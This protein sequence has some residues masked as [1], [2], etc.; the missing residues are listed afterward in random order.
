M[1][2]LVR[3]PNPTLDDL[4]SYF[5]PEEWAT[6]LRDITCSRR[7]GAYFADA[8]FTY[9][10]PARAW[11]ISFYRDELRALTPAPHHPDPARLTR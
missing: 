6:A 11:F 8:H 4:K 3:A 10:E 5:T 9:R 7:Y 2:M 1:R